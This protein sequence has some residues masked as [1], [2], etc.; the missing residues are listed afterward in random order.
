MGAK[1]FRWFLF[2]VIIAVIPI[3]LSGL[4]E[5]YKTWIEWDNLIS[6]KKADIIFIG[7]AFCAV[8]IGELLES[9]TSNIGMPKALTHFLEGFSVITLVGGTALYVMSLIGKA[10]SVPTILVYI[11]SV[12]S[13]FISTGCVALSEFL[14]KKITEN[15]LKAAKEKH[16]NEMIQI[17]SE[18]SDI[19]QTCRNQLIIDVCKK[20]NLSLSPQ[21]VAQVLQQTE[22]SKGVSHADF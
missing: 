5:G 6:K 17:I 21:Q 11:T 15:A 10:E 4:I 12:A 20:L 7:V 14:E 19:D 9:S 16:G 22:I 3:V 1:S 18:R 8:G 2:T 13:I